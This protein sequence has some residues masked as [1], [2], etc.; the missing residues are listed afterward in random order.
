VRREEEMLEKFLDIVQKVGLD[1]AR[2]LIEQ[3]LALDPQQR[4]D[5]I[6][7]F[8]RSRIVQQQPRQLNLFP[9]GAA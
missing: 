4:A 6:I 9:N 1:K 2:E 8:P 3:R 7:P 5:N